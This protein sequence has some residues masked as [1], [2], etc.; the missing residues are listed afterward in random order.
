[1]ADI[2][3]NT[4]T[5]STI[6]VGGIVTGSVEVRE[7]HDWYKINLTAG[8]QITISLGGIGFDSLVDPYLNLRNSSGAIVTYNDDSGGGRNAKIVFTV[9][10]SGTYYI[11]A[12]AWDSS[13]AVPWTP[14]AETGYTGTGS[15]T[16]SVQNYTPPPLVSYDQIADQLVSGYWNVQGGESPHNFNVTQ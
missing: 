14:G 6:A 1:M 13:S 10:Q 9:T 12:G 15:Y 2:P 16:L 3:A 4:S 8:Q 11:D 5:T 7:D